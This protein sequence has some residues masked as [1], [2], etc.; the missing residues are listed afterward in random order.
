MPLHL[1]APEA[2]AA[3]PDGKGWNRLSLN[4][5]GGFLAQCALRPRR[6]GALLESQ[7]TRRARWGGF[8]PCIRRGQCDGCPVREA[9]YG[10]CTVVPVNAPRVLVRVEP[11]FATDARF[12]GPDG[13]RLWITTGPDDRN[14]GDRQPWTW[15]QAARV[16][17]W[18]IGRM[19]A[20]EHG[21]GFW[22]ERT[23][24]VPALG[25]VITTRARP[26]FTRH[27]FRVA[28]CRVALLHC[29]GECTHDTELL[30][31]I[32]HACAGPE[33]ANEERVPVRWT[34]V[35]EM[36]PQPTGRIR[37]GVDVRPMTV[38]VTATEDTRC[39]MAR[40]TLTGSGWTTERVRA[41]GEAL[42]AHL[43][44]RAN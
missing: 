42:R 40:L 17:G 23:T 7:D 29:A 28:R 30:N 11:V 13:Y 10:Q 22:L 16:Q 39:Q 21:E 27:A 44:D 20:D 37:F 24:R 14:Y 32:S 9:L 5:H 36:T 43:A 25:C 4:A 8:G 26:S 38:Q 35:P 12:C 34:Q 19:Y 33:G 18:D 6:W 1:P 3:G 2:P 15:D 31:A 41:A